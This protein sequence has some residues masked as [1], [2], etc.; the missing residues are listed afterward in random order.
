ML[1]HAYLSSEP[2]FLG[3]RSHST[4]PALLCQAVSWGSH[5]VAPRAGV[6]HVFY[7]FPTDTQL[8]LAFFWDKQAFRMFLQYGFRGRKWDGWV[9]GKIHMYLLIFKK[10]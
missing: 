4:S 1:V 3:G 7:R 10:K 9:Q 2:P 6:L 5:L 8:C